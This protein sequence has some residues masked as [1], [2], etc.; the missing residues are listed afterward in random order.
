MT[1]NSIT[2]VIYVGYIRQILL[3]DFNTLLTSSPSYAV[4]YRYLKLI[5]AQHITAHQ[6]ASRRRTAAAA[7]GGGGGGDDDDDDTLAAGLCES[8]F[9][10]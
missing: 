3:D 7:A 5:P 8:P 2:N 4:S 9:D 6:S 10:H 1:I